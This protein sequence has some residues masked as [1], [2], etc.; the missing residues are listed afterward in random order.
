MVLLANYANIAEESFK[1]ILIFV[2]RESFVQNED[3]YSLFQ[4]NDPSNC[5]HDLFE[6]GDHFIGYENQN[7]CDFRKFYFPGQ[8][9]DQM[10]SFNALIRNIIYYLI[11]T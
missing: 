2:L 1:L 5:R 6:V 10:G 8:M 9:I 11:F 4:T 7:E 3:G